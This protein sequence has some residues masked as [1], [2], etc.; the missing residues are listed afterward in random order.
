MSIQ[1]GVAGLCP[2]NHGPRP[3][4]PVDDMTRPFEIRLRVRSLGAKAVR[5]T[6][7]ASGL[8]PRRGTKSS[9]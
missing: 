3:R 8:Q 4:P 2:P 7:K 9:G 5:L 6:V 1:I